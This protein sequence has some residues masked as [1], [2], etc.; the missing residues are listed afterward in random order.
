MRNIPGKIAAVKWAKELLNMMKEQE[1]VSDKFLKQ[2]QHILNTT[3]DYLLLKER[4]VLAEIYFSEKLSKITA[5]IDWHTKEYKT[6]KRVKEYITDLTN[7]SHQ[8]ASKKKEL[9]NAVDM[10]TSLVTVRETD[11]SPDPPPA[12]PNN[13]P[14]LQ[15]QTSAAPLRQ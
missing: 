13:D 15:R 5:S 8:A 4:I 10:A 3:K 14:G 7:L 12:S 6:F 1:E 11:P 9:A 2:L